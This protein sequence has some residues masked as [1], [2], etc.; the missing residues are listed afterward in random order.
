MSIYQLSDKAISK[1]N[2]FKITLAKGGITIL[3]GMYLMAPNMTKEQRKALYELGGV[4]QN[5]EDINDI[6]EDLE[7]GIKTLSN[8]KMITY[9]EMKQLYLGTVNNIIKQCK[10]DPYSPHLTL[11]IM[12]WL[13]K[14]ILEKRYAPFFNEK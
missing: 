11:D 5:F 1:D 14:S 4:L 9:D 3:A 12:S 8:Q 13:I 10:L 7:L 2:L 6:H